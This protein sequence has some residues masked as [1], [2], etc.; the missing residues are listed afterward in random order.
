MRAKDW[1]PVDEGEVGLG[2]R[3]HFHRN[4]G[5]KLTHMGVSG[6]SGI[7][8]IVDSGFRACPVQFGESDSRQLMLESDCLFVNLILTRLESRNH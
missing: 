2:L 8:K 1:T 5:E 4:N 7:S 6:S 3:W